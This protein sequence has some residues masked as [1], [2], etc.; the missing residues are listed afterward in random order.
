MYHYF[1]LY[2]GIVNNENASLNIYL[3]RHFKLTQKKKYQTLLNT[4]IS[5]E[6]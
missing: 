4:T 2:I 3:F 1:N 6:T 5:A